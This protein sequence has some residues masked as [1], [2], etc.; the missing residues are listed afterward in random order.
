MK[1]RNTL[2]EL[3]IV[4]NI[5]KNRQLEKTKADTLYSIAK[6]TVIVSQTQSKSQ[7]LTNVFQDRALS[8]A[9][10]SML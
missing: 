2:K 7:S 3:I 6:F 1:D 9:Y 4:N 5:F 8:G 10:D